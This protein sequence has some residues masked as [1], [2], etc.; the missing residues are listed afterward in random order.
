[1]C[2]GV[3]QRGCHST[4]T[5]PNPDLEVLSKQA[6]SN[7]FAHPPRP[8]KPEQDVSGSGSD[9]KARVEADSDSSRSTHHTLSVHLPAAAPP[10]LLLSPR[11]VVRATPHPISLQQHEADG[12]ATSVLPSPPHPAPL[13]PRDAT[14]KRTPPRYW[15][16][17]H[18]LTRDGEPD[19]T[20]KGATGLPT[21]VS[22]ST[23]GQ[24]SPWPP[25]H[26]HRD[27]QRVS[28]TGRWKAKSGLSATE[29]GTRVVVPHG[30]IKKGHVAGGGGGGRVSGTGKEESGGSSMRV[31]GMAVR[32]VKTLLRRAAAIKGG[33]SS[34]AAKDVVDPHAHARGSE[35]SGATHGTTRDARGGSARSSRSS[36]RSNSNN[37][38][39]NSSNTSRV[40]RWLS[41]G[42]AVS[43]RSASPGQRTRASS[44]GSGDDGKRA[45]LSLAQASM[46]TWVETVLERTVDMP[47]HARLQSKLNRPLPAAIL[48]KYITTHDCTA[49]DVQ[50]IMC[51]FFIH[52]RNVEFFETLAQFLIRKGEYVL[53]CVWVWVCGC[54]GVWVCGCVGVWVAWVQERRCSRLAS[55][56]QAAACV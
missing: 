25:R 32:F 30:A 28:S 18:A 31:A 35:W 38:S 16:G 24:H 9:G 36:S 3:G 6:V 52:N 20:G 13:S 2:Y 29:P 55:P 37:G 45:Q 21:P 56:F 10:Q 4:C 26:Q 33:A 27:A 11:R 44:R 47:H 22:V 42:G 53:P 41:R 49:A 54:V 40:H 7:R 46:L 5:A 17:V 50:R 39:N 48:T 15:G 19:A 51:T 23:S 43:D 12:G 8:C 14:T 34:A 1:M